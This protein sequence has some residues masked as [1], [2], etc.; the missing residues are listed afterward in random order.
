MFGSVRLVNFRCF[1]DINVSLK[2]KR[3]SLKPN[4][5]LFG[6]NSSGKSSF[7]L[8]F[9]YLKTITE[10]YRINYELKVRNECVQEFEVNPFVLKD[11][12]AKHK[13]KNSIGDMRLE[14]EAVIDGKQYFYL[15]VFSDEGCLKQE[16]LT[17]K[18]NN[19]TITVFEATKT[20]LDVGRNVILLKDMNEINQMHS[21]SFGMYSMLSYFGYLLEVRKDVQLKASLKEF[22]DFVLRASIM[23]DGHYNQREIMGF[24]WNSSAVVS[25]GV[26][27]RSV[28]NL[29]N[30]SLPVLNELIESVFPLVDRMEY[31]FESID[32]DHWKYEICAYKKTSLGIV[33][34]SYDELPSGFRKFI[35]LS[36]NFLEL[37]LGRCVI[38]DQFDLGLHQSP[39]LNIIQNIIPKLPGQLIVSLDS[40]DA[41]N[42]I[43]PA[44]IYVTNIK[45]LIFGVEAIENIAPSQPNHNIR[46]RYEQGVFGTPVP[47]RP[48]MLHSMMWELRAG[49]VEVLSKKK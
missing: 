33:K 8:S 5:Y 21:Q 10:G 3:G 6:E 28:Y 7:L 29:L 12:Y 2:N 37:L 22:V 19:R 48:N 30:Q 42:H 24:L 14:F 40:L 17:K 13:R 1:D 31:I 32:E 20:R 11:E 26:A 46:N 27:N 16:R 39:F 34:V 41:M 47:T 36:I 45:D 49:V 4:I 9:A 23:I 25:K 18:L 44:S 35:G 43:E 15:M 38:V